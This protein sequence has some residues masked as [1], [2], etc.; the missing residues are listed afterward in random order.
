MFRIGIGVC[1]ILIVYI[2][3]SEGISGKSVDSVHIKGAGVRQIGDFLCVVV[4]IIRL[5]SVS[6]CKLFI[7]S[8]FIQPQ[9]NAMP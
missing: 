2:G 6:S 3:N 7:R 4:E 5:L 9:T 8:Y 1:W